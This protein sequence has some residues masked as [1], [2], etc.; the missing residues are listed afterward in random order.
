MRLTDYQVAE[1]ILGRCT[2]RGAPLSN[3]YLQAALVAVQDWCKQ[4]GEPQL[5]WLQ[6]ESVKGCF[7]RFPGVYYKYCGFGA[8][9]IHIFGI[10]DLSAAHPSPEGGVGLHRRQGRRDGVFGA[11]PLPLARN[12]PLPY[13]SWIDSLLSRNYLWGAAFCPKSIESFLHMISS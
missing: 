13:P 11:V 4:S 2:A 8:N 9:P 6:K 7:F 1:Y 12:S 5:I 3:L 10:P